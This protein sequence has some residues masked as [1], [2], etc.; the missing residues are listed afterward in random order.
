M[1]KTFSEEDFKKEAKAFEKIH[2]K[3][4]AYIWAGKKISKSLHQK[5]KY[6]FG[7]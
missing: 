6:N 2:G 4:T 7:G 3:D 5:R 1:I